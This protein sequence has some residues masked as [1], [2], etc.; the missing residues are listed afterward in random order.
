MK[1]ALML[2]AVVNLIFVLAVSAFFFK[3]SIVE[4][5]S[6]DEFVVV[7][8]KQAD[9]CLKGGGCA[10]FSQRE[11]E[12]TLMAYITMIIRRQQGG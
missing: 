4:V 9:E 3:Y 8:R 7:Q 2:L 6:G 5:Q 1:I 12:Q 10:I 11:F